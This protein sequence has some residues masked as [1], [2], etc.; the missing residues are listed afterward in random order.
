MEGK[1]RRAKL[2]EHIDVERMVGL[3]IGPLCRPIVAR[4]DGRIHYLDHATTEELQRKYAGDKNVDVA[5]ICRVDFVWQGAT[6]RETIPD[7][8]TFDYVIASHV[9][10]HVP[11]VIGWLQQIGEILR[12]GGVLS[13]AV[14][15]RRYTFDYLRP[16]STLAELVESY[17]RGDTR[18]SPRQIFDF[19]GNVIEVDAAAAWSPGFAPD[20]SKR[21]HSDEAALNL[22]REGVKGERYI[23]V[24]CTVYTADSFVDLLGQ[25][26]RLDLLDFEVASFFPPAP[27][28]IEF[29]V[30]LR[31]LSRV[32]GHERLR[33]QL[34][35]LPGSIPSADALPVVALPVVALPLGALPADALPPDASSPSPELAGAQARLAGV[36]ASRSWRWT[37]PLRA[38]GNRTTAVRRA[39]SP[40]VRPPDWLRRRAELRLLRET[41]LFDAAF[42][43]ESYPDV[44]RSGLGAIEHYLCYG[45]AEGRDPHALFDTEY[46]LSHGRDLEGFHTPLAH[47]L[48]RGAAAGRNP[49]ALFDQAF[50]EATGP[51]VASFGLAAVVH[52]VTIGRA[53][54]RRTHPLFDPDYYRERYA[55]ARGE[56]ID[57]L[58]HY[59]RHGLS[60]DRDPNPLFDVAYYRER[61][62][63]V[64]AARVN[65]VDHFFRFGWREGRNPSPLF[66]T[67]LY[68]RENPGVLAAGQNPLAHFLDSL[69]AGVPLSAGSTCGL[70]R[71]RAA[72]PE[73]ASRP[74]AGETTPA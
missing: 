57:P 4:G 30:S 3:E 60:E 17:V 9:I 56:G 11:N 42:Y 5:G 72:A 28:T 59:L 55:D 32:E 53:E 21:F 10:E 20:R 46:Y 51:D 52:Y 66:D 64:V 58:A 48:Q 13:L 18:P 29:F 2:L 45:A 14:P 41:R 70:S 44:A 33:L 74:E 27:G 62:P 1:D 37:K 35:S 6:L 26:F 49:N 73:G 63:D 12:P 36:L 39:L 43:L 34:E 19:C 23:D 16:V 67:L 54:N 25:I 38:L 65:P 15:D 71:G 7:G 68:L 61:S 47:Y 31:K 50:Y 22:A 40:L 24:H 8:L 69:P